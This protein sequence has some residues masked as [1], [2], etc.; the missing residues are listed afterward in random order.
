MLSYKL[1][2]LVSNPDYIAIITNFIGTVKLSQELFCIN[3]P[4]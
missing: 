3:R 1:P 4:H 2:G